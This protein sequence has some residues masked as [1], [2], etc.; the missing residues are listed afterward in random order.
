M[1]VNS[2]E[3]INFK[4]KKSLR[5]IVAESAMLIGG[6]LSF[7]KFT[8]L[9]LFII[10]SLLLIAGIFTFFFSGWIMMSKAKYRELEEAAEDSTT[11]KEIVNEFG[12]GMTIAGIIFIAALVIGG[13]FIL[14]ILSHSWIKTVFM[15]IAF[16]FVSDLR[17][18]FKLK[19]QEE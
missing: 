11:F 18:Y 10:G 2:E 9:P 5:Y 12:I 1:N 3:L 15:V 13:I 4:K 8:N 16:E 19:Y 6:I 14:Y 7:G 17:G